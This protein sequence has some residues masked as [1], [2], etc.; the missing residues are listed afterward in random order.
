M[1]INI[2]SHHSA[3]KKSD[4]KDLLKIMKI[5]LLFL[6]V[7]AFQLS[8]VNSNAQDAAIK[9][10]SNTLTIGEL[11]REIEKQTDYL[12]VYSNREVDTEKEILLKEKTN[13]VSEY[14][15]E[16]FANSDI[17]HDFEN[18][19]IVLLKK[20]DQNA[21][22]IAQMI[23]TAQQEGKTVTGTV[24]DKNG[25]SIIGATIVD[26]DD[27]SHGTITDIDGNFILT[28]V[29]ENG[30]LHVSYVGMKTQE[31][32][33]NGRL[34]ISI[35]MEPD[36]ELLDELVVVGYG[37]QRK[38]TVTGSIATTSG[39]ELAS[40]PTP[41]V[42]NTLAGRLPGLIA[43]NRS[44]EPG[45][46]D[47]ELLIRGRSTTGD[48][49]PLIVV[50]GVADRA[51]GFS[52]IDPHD[53]ESVTILKD[54]SAAIYGSRA[55]NGV[56][57]VTTK[58]GNKG[59]TIVS[60]SGNIGFSS[61]T[62]LPKMSSSWQYAELQNE[63]ESSIYG[64]SNKYTA[65]QIQSFKDGSDLEKY[66][67]ISIF[68]EMIRR[69]APQ[70]QH[71]LSVA[72]GNDLVN[73]FVS[74]GYQY[75][76]NYYKNSAS[77]YS[78]Y[79]LRSNIDINPHENFKASINISLRQENRNSPLYGSEDIWRYMVKYDPMVNI[80][81][82]GTDYPTLAS[83]DNYSPSTAVDGSMG[84]QQNDR[85]YVNTDIILHYDMPFITKGIS[86]DAGLYIDRSDLMYK[87][88]SKQFNLFEKQENDYIPRKYGPSNAT[89]R[90]NMDQSLGITMNARLN[91]E[92]TF[93]NKHNTKAFVAYE[94]YS[95]RYEFLSAY[96]QDY[97]SSNIDQIF[98][99]DKTTAQND[100]TAS[101]AARINF[102]GRLDYDYLGKYLA[103]FNWRYDG[104][105]N[106]PKGN[107]FG[108]FPGASIGWRISEE[109]FWKENVP[110]VHNLKLRA[111]V[112][113]MGNDRVSAFQYMTTY[114]FQNP[115]ILGGDNPKPQTG[116]WQ[117]RT[118][119]P[120]I[121]WEVSTNYNIGLEANFLKDFNFEL[122]IFKTKRENIL[123]TRNASI[124]EYAG[125]T[126]PDENIG[127][128]STY[129]TEILLNY[130]KNLG[131]FKLNIG[132][133]FTY[134]KSNI[135]Y[136][137]EPAGVM[138]WQKRTNKPIGANWVMYET[139][140][141][142]RTQDDLDNNPHM[143]NAKLGDLMFRD[144]D[145]NGTIDGNDRVRLDKTPIPEIMYGINLGLDWKQ[146]S[147]SSLFQGAARTWQYTFFE[148]GSIGNFTEDFYNNHW[149]EDNIHAKYPRVYDREATVTGLKNTFWLQ[150]ASYL[151]LKNI[152]L[153]YTLSEMTLS[154]TPFSGLRIFLSGYNLLTLT[155]MK[156]LD[157]ETR[158]GGQG[159]ASWS[160]PH[161]KVCSFGVNITF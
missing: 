104:S 160:T 147:L 138:E 44:G 117:Q 31:I 81:W 72:G 39:T 92:R 143:S 142:F 63:I 61:P 55:A 127:E 84:Y 80:Y 59:K 90:E 66:P 129:G 25:E 126:L 159:F 119:N 43:S 36:I 45:Y 100:G 52:R 2:S 88:F 49:S 102:F 57:L 18:N 73:Y 89:L 70:T 137:D 157:P 86:V 154:K 139:I 14:L 134:A 115:A 131:D 95:H 155:G 58:R 40:V 26:K 19:Y 97:I 33:L 128:C 34:N 122:D 105:E 77:D 94:Q 47:S 60:Y 64:R 108:F 75:Q 30:T 29:S 65:E 48:S 23:E 91:Y 140:G 107:R 7:F 118:A 135:D 37:T 133:N 136:I 85:S 78:Q 110:W 124:P 38:V 120:N 50:D 149:T 156:N 152:E 3:I 46:D 42:A 5:S 15:K 87:N 148:S 132:G 82:P 51:G 106:F 98:A 125:L 16:A 8:A 101:E 54:A 62:V 13:K 150:N 151:R 93:A 145:E 67:N 130:R 123:A 12:V 28:G 9:L 11:I 158:E 109:D 141:I 153:S 74:T 32:Q 53:I 27:P 99:G 111:S 144:V 103:Q 10:K 83:Q 116:I 4:Y 161:S 114:T 96:R 41:S 68:D 121:T 20:I 113:K 1:K 146:W 22:A 21:S 79:N 35:V 6:F 76:E 71:N 17:G 24:K 69:G 56:I 112:G